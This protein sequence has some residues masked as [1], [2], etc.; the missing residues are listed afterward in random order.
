MQPPSQFPRREGK[1]ELDPTPR[2]LSIFLTHARYTRPIKA[3]WDREAD[4][5]VGELAAERSRELGEV[6]H[7]TGENKWRMM[8]REYSCRPIWYHVE[9][10]RG[11]DLWSSQNVSERDFPLRWFDRV[12]V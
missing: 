8:V 3:A 6:R 2:P 7:T 5:D 12:V 11:L 10:R 1:S 9:N 4:E